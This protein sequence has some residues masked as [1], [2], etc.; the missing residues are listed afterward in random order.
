M[1]KIFKNLN[2]K[3]VGLIAIICALITLGATSTIWYGTFNGVMNFTGMSGF[4]TNSNQGIYYA[5]DWGFTTTN[6]AH[7]NWL[8]ISNC[9][10]VVSNIGGGT[11]RYGGQFS[12]NTGNEQ[13]ILVDGEIFIPPLAGQTAR[14]KFMGDGSTEIVYTGT[15]TRHGIVWGLFDFENLFVSSQLALSDITNLTYPGTNL[16]GIYEVGYDDWNGKNFRVT[17]CGQGLAIEQ[18]GSYRGGKAEYGDLEDCGIGVASGDQN[19]HLILDQVAARACVWV[20]FDLACVVPDPTDVSVYGPSGQ[21][22]F[23]GGTNVAASSCGIIRGGMNNYDYLTY[24]EGKGTWTI[25]GISGNVVPQVTNSILLVLGHPISL[26]IPYENETGSAT[27]IV[28]NY[29][30]AGEDGAPRATNIWAYAANDN[31]LLLGCTHIGVDGQGYGIVGDFSFFH[32]DATVSFN[33]GTNWLNGYGSP[34]VS[35]TGP[36]TYDNGARGWT[37]IEANNGTVVPAG[38]KTFSI[39][40]HDPGSVSFIPFYWSAE[41]GDSSTIASW[42]MND[43]NRNYTL[44]FNNVLISAPTNVANVNFFW[45]PRT[46]QPLKLTNNTGGR[47][48]FTV[49][50]FTTAGATWWISNNITGEFWPFSVSTG[51]TNSWTSPPLSPGDWLLMT[52]IAGVINTSTNGVHVL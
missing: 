7:K 11:I 22:I 10:T 8:A 43:V 21:N 1:F 25:S 34:V 29:E 44:T 6:T 48:S 42:Y 13:Q 19:D 31:L 17:A 33:V 2:K 47:C 30:T 40:V 27:M 26:G 14:I 4:S 3:E 38:H 52:N 51:E 45:W 37:Y 24:V 49:N 50:W 9:I 32:A 41:F 15:K 35:W 23:Y 16:V 46:N 12:G 5:S 39:R 36:Y 20:G 28:D 18:T